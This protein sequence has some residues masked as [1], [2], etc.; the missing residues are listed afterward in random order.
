MSVT[1]Y[2]LFK[3]ECEH[4]TRLP[5]HAVISNPVHCIECQAQTRITTIQVEE[6]HAYCTRKECRYSAWTGMSK[7]LANQA[8]NKHASNTGHYATSHIEWADNPAS[9][10]ALKRMQAQ[11]VLI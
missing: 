10:A 1:L 9:V 2:L 6:W 7:E 3:M 4:I 11:G 5:A 8:A